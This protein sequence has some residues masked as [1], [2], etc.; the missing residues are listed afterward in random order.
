MRNQMPENPEVEYHT[1]WALATRGNT[2]EAVHRLKKASLSGRL[3]PD[4]KTD[5]HELLQQRSN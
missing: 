4:T 3:P 5:A 2:A 1:A